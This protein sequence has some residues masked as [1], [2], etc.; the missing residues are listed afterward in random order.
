MVLAT[1]EHHSFGPTANAA[2][3]GHRGSAEPG[4][5]WGSVARP[6]RSGQ[7]RRWSG[8]LL[9]RRGGQKEGGGGEGGGVQRDTGA[10]APLAGEEQEEEGEEE[11]AEASQGL[12][13][14]I[15]SLGSSAGT[16]S[17]VSL[18]G[19]SGW[20]LPSLCASFPNFGTTSLVFTRPTGTQESSSF[21]VCGCQWISCL[22]YVPRCPMW[23]H[24]GYLCGGQ[25]CEASGSIRLVLDVLHYPGGDSVLVLTSGGLAWISSCPLLL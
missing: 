16:C 10:G 1:V 14:T 19:S 21:W 23:R 24:L 13:S 17:C 22:W 18:R 7:Q 6:R 11:E 12:L 8:R 20:R 4:P 2:P 9:F 3:R 5:G 15:L 25:C